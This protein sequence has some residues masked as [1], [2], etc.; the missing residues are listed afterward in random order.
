MGIPN[1]ENIFAS[2]ST[3]CVFQRLQ[4]FAGRIAVF[5][6]A[7]DIGNGNS[8]FAGSVAFAGLRKKT[9]AGAALQP[10]PQR[11]SPHTIQSASSMAAPRF[12]YWHDG[13]TQQGRCPADSPRITQNGD[14]PY[15]Y[16]P[17]DR[18]GVLRAASPTRVCWD[19]ISIR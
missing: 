1:R 10:L 8:G 18:A 19:R 6:L 2:V 14:F 16:L 3:R 15:W 5:S 7:E 9:G 17:A 13:K 11:P 12:N 4:W